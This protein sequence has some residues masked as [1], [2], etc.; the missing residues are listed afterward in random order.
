MKNDPKRKKKQYHEKHNINMKSVEFQIYTCGN[1][2]SYNSLVTGSCIQNSHCCV[3][4]SCGR[5]LVVLYRILSIAGHA[6]HKVGLIHSKDLLKKRAYDDIASKHGIS[7]CE[8]MTS[9]LCSDI[10]IEFKFIK[11]LIFYSNYPI[12]LY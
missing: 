6:M 1:K 4:V 2:Y 5:P 3:Q 11:Q 9:H 12:L 7:M 10:I 8:C